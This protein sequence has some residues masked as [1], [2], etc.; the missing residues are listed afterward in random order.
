MN[1]R[2]NETPLDQEERDLAHEIENDLYEE[3]SSVERKGILSAGKEAAKNYLEKNKNINLR[4][5][6]SDIVKIKVKAA[7]AGLPYQTLA[8]SILHQYANEKFQ[9]GL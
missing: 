9:I 2:Y 3:V 4:L 6:Y 5:S 7:E 8:A 1:K